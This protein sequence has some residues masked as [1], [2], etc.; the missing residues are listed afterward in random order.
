M[1]VDA[2]AIIAILAGEEENLA[3]FR[4]LE[5]ADQPITSALAV[6]EAASAICRKKSVSVE[7]AEAEL[8][9][10]LEHARIHVVAMTNT[11]AHGALAA[12][13]RYGKGRGHKA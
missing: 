3:L 13:A 2:S 10:L 12:Y 5:A 8:R 7:M 6:F 1:F 9:G 11:E 4:C